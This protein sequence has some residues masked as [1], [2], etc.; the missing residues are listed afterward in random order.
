MACP[1]N[2]YSWNML[3]MHINSQGAHMREPQDADWSRLRK[4]GRNG[5]YLMVVGLMWWHDMISNNKTMGEWLVMVEDVSWVLE[6][7]VA[8]HIDESV[9]PTPSP[10]SPS[11]VHCGKHKTTVVESMNSGS[12]IFYKCANNQEQPQRQ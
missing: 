7:M 4:A 9:S 3:G 12:R 11:T 8:T 6:S 2:S 5:M 10:P 1:T